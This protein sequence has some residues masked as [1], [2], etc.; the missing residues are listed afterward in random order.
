MRKSIIFILLVSL[1]L[2]SSCG[3]SESANDESMSDNDKAGVSD[4]N[5][6]DPWNYT[7][8][9][10]EDPMAICN[11]F[12]DPFF[13]LDVASALNKKVTDVVTYE[14]LENYSGELDCGP[15]PLKSIEGIGLLKNL[16]SFSCAKN[17]LEIIPSEFCELKELKSINLLKAYSI[18][19]L[20]EEIGDLKK[21]DFFRVDMTSLKELPPGIGGCENL[22]VLNIA[23]TE[24]TSLPAEIGDLKKLEFIDMHS[25]DLETVPDSICKLTNLKSLDIGYTKLK[26]LPADI[27][28]LSELIRLNLFGCELETLPNSIQNMKQL[29]YLNVYDNYELD[30][31]YKKWFDP[32]VYTCKDDPE[33]DDEWIGKWYYNE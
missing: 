2:L 31:S 1:L 12:P 8:P 5:N 14:E 33:E 25:N 13:A 9:V 3:E 10:S 17:D 6:I 4:S 22:R 30:E 18:E 7:P 28:D 11:I 23:N 16:T 32:K 29:R 21:L 19:K 24:I 27:G 15:S 20:P 26:Y